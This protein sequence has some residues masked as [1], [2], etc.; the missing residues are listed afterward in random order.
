MVTRGFQENKAEQL[1]CRRRGNCPRA[2]GDKLA[3]SWLLA[4]EVCGDDCKRVKKKSPYNRW[5]VSMRQGSEI[6]TRHRGRRHINTLEQG[7]SRKRVFEVV[8]LGGSREPI[9]PTTSRLSFL[10]LF[11]KP[12][13]LVPR[14]GCGVPQAEV[15]VQLLLLASRR[16][17]RTARR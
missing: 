4:P 9:P 8:K 3:V 11:T 17:L 2:R 14:P 15:G 10:G 1:W 16:P 13:S 6:L 12:E 5:Q 7:R